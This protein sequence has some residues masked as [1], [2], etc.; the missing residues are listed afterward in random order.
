MALPKELPA[1][2]VLVADSSGNQLIPETDLSFPGVE[3][4]RQKGSAARVAFLPPAHPFWTSSDRRPSL[5]DQ[6]VEGY[7]RAAEAPTLLDK[8]RELIQPTAEGTLRGLAG[9]LP[10]DE[11]TLPGYLLGTGVRRAF[12]V[13]PG[14]ANALRAARVAQAVPL[15]PTWAGAGVGSAADRRLEEDP[16]VRAS[17]GALEN[18]RGQTGAAVEQFLL[19]LP[20]Q[21][22]ESLGLGG[23]GAGS[24]ARQLAEG[25]AG[26]VATNAAQSFM[27]EDTA[28]GAREAA[29]AQVTTPEGLLMN[30][31]GAAAPV[32]GQAVRERMQS[33]AAT[34]AAAVEAAQT[35]AAEL[36]DEVRLEADNA[37]QSRAATRARLEE[38][39]R[40]NRTA[41][42]AP[43]AEPVSPPASAGARPPPFEPTAV[44]VP[45]NERTNTSA[46]RT[47]EP[48]AVRAAQ[49]QRAEAMIAALPPE[50]QALYRARQAQPE[51]PKPPLGTP[52]DDSFIM[53]LG[54]FIDPEQRVGTVVDAA[55]RD[56][57]PTRNLRAGAAAAAAEAA[58]TREVPPIPLRV[59]V[60]Q[61]AISPLEL[62][63]P[64]G[65]RPVQTAD[66]RVG[67][68]DP[69]RVGDTTAVA[70]PRGLEPEA[71]ATWAERVAGPVAAPAVIKLVTPVS[72][73][74]PARKPGAA[75]RAGFG[76]PPSRGG[77]GGGGSGGGSR[78]GNT[79]EPSRTGTMPTAVDPTTLTPAGPPVSAKPVLAELPLPQLSMWARIAQRLASPLATVRAVN[80]AVSRAEFRA[81]KDLGFL[82]RQTE[83]ARA[84]HDAYFR[85]VVPMLKAAEAAAPQQVRRVIRD[86]RDGRAT[87]ADLARLPPEFRE[88]F[89]VLERQNDAMRGWLADHGYFTPAELMA[90]EAKKAAG[91][92]WLHRD[93]KAFH[94]ERWRP[95]EAARRRAERY[96]QEQGMSPDDAALEVRRLEEQVW[97]Q[98]RAAAAESLLGQRGIL[99]QRKL[100]AP[101]HQFLGIIDD[102]SF[103]VAATHGQLARL[104]HMARVTEAMASPQW[105]GKG[106]AAQWREGLHPQPLWDPQLTPAANR[107]KFGALAGRFVTPEWREAVTDFA[108]PRAQN[109]LQQ[110]AQ[111]PVNVMRVAKTLYSPVSWVRDFLSNS[112]Y[113]AVAGF[114]PARWPA[115][116]RKAFQAM[117]AW[118]KSLDVSS[119]PEAQWMQWALED[120]AV[121]AGKGTDM[122]GSSAR[123][124]VKRIVREDER[125]MFRRLLNAE[126]ELRVWL[127]EHRDLMD[128]AWR[129]AAYLDNVDRGIRAGL[130]LTEAR[131]RA[132]HVVNRYF[133]SSATVADGI[134][135]VS[136][137]N[138]GLA[139]FMLWSVDNIR[140]AK[141]IMVDA[142]QGSG[143]PAIRAALWWALPAV[144]AATARAVMGITDDEVLA[145]EA[146]LPPG[147]RAN[148]PVHD[149]IPLR[150][151]DGQ[152]RYS[153]SFEALNP[154]TTFVRNVG[155]P[156]LAAG[157]AT[158]MIR[159][160]TDGG[161]LGPQM[162]ATLAQL[163][164]MQEQRQES[165]LPGALVQQGFDRAWSFFAPALAVQAADVARRAGLAGQLRATEE[166][167]GLLEAMVARLS[168]FPIAVTGPRSAAG[169]QRIA[170]GEFGK[171][172][173]D[174]R[175]G[176]RLQDPALRESVLNAAQSRREEL[177]RQRASPATM[178]QLGPLSFPRAR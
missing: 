156:N 22:L 178:L 47:P 149:W 56:V 159:A 28:A 74:V 24:K 15:T 108:D 60:G 18:E 38:L 82:V 46:P 52:V 137:S 10:N 155:Q 42:A 67:V 130:E 81:G 116:I 174:V 73:P 58:P 85:R 68:A 19:G 72:Q 2:H 30:L 167:Q 157:I 36:L 64:R 124:M 77:G 129:L 143:G 11:G 1:G 63:V 100:P 20:G 86:L 122:I 160:L 134:R 153:I 16:N 115:G 76:S 163:G 35:R 87:A 83:Q 161:W 13:E 3:V 127:A 17:V 78:S 105:E 33:R 146:R 43:P 8:L 89:A 133:A 172:K 125:T 97:G 92:V 27:G 151:P 5:V 84:A 170:R 95:G 75:G 139:P 126:S 91:G 140:V 135:Q 37:A 41:A 26:N 141:N 25:F 66:M 48:T 104:Y 96:F 51:V 144:G 131:A 173:G 171:T 165:P 90:I 162:D 142:A 44:G 158:N 109:V 21:V 70:R 7:Q 39:R 53:Q 168:P 119:A 102:P 29:A 4:F 9:A 114:A 34:K 12:G 145:A 31:L 99:K 55:P 132:S 107:Q 121:R 45:S 79:P 69:A 23:G 71:P 150:G 154:F 80:Q 123:N 61:S 136:N 88:R 14:S 138:F 59:A 118:N 175:Q 32:A 176:N 166:P 101:L 113:A 106:W 54:R 6:A 50:V 152:L 169:A 65:P 128:N 49:A 110:M 93:Y 94:D 164:M 103:V 98:G 112:M 111:A 148:N 40:A 62:T 177:A 117:Q 147:W 57:Q 120:G